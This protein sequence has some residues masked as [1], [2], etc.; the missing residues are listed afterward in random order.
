MEP[1]QRSVD[2]FGFLIGGVNGRKVNFSDPEILTFVVVIYTVFVM[3]L[4]E[5]YL[6]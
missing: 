2:N 5:G 4:I 1:T 3:W 6:V